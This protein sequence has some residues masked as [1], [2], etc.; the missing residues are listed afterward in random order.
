MIASLTGIVR[1]R[2]EQG[3]TLDV[4]GVG[5][6][7]RTTSAVVE[8]TVLDQSATFTTYLH[9][10][11]DAL[12]LYGFLESAE[13][14]LFVRLLSVSGVGPKVALTLLGS[15]SFEQLTGAIEAGN[16]ATLRSV[17][18][19]GSKTAERIIIDLRGK[20]TTHA[21][22]QGIDDLASALVRL[23]YSAKEARE[24]ARSAPNDG[25]LEERLKT[26]LRNLGK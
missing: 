7:I 16:A 14:D 20:L 26:A 10:R 11:E 13:R 25:T 2:H 15:L 17:S 3:I 18:G 1:V 12:D 5:F 6:A 21:D 24:A 4:H 23:G 8:K 9:V 19:V 22:D